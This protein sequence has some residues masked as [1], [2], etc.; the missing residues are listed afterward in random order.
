MTSKEKSDDNL[1]EN[2]ISKFFKLLERME[3][4]YNDGYNFELNEGLIHRPS[5]DVIMDFLGD[6]GLNMEDNQD[7]M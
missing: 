5:D 7:V 3:N 1:N 2:L 6:L 4:R